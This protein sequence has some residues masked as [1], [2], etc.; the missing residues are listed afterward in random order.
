MCFCHLKWRCKA[1]RR[2]DC[3]FIVL[4]FRL[5]LQSI[6]D[7]HAALQTRTQRLLATDMYFQIRN[8]TQHLFMHLVKHTDEHCINCVPNTASIA[9]LHSPLS[10]RKL[11]GKRLVA[12]RPTQNSSASRIVENPASYS[13]PR[14]RK[15]LHLWSL[16]WFTLTRTFP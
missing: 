10:P 7:I 15:R 11:C 4:L 16:P 8:A 5:R 9:R 13:R 6:E 2:L 14:T 3:P 12:T 1:G